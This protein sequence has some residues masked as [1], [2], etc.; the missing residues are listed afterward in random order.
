[1]KRL[2]KKSNDIPKVDNNLINKLR[3]EVKEDIYNQNQTNMLLLNELDEADVRHG[4][5]P[6]CRHEQ[7]V[8]KDGFKICVDCESIYKIFDG[9]TYFIRG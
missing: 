4:K 8:S 2:I 3:S 9:K 5:C 6:K 7:L 1:M